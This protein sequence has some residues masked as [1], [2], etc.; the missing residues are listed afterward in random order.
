MSN[1][2]NLRLTARSSIK[3]QYVCFSTPTPNNEGVSEDIVG[4]DL[5]MFH[6]PERKSPSIR[7]SDAKD[8]N[9]NLHGST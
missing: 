3:C 7:G 4:N 1:P 8:R 6:N 2:K 9:D 5:R